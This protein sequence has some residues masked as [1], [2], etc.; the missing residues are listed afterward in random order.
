MILQAEN[1]IKRYQNQ[2]ALDYFSMTINE[3]E[4]IG[5]LGPNGAGKTTFIKALIGLLSIDEGEINLA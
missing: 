5:L 4:V 3:G 1:V 2:L